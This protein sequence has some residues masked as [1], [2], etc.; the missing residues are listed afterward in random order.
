[1]SSIHYQLAYPDLRKN[2]HESSGGYVEIHD[3]HYN[4]EASKN[5]ETAIFLAQRGFKVRLLPVD[6]TPGIKNPDAYLID[7]KLIIEF[8]HNQTPTASAIEN[9]LRDAKKQADN[10]L[11]HV[12]GELTKGALIRG[13]QNRLHRDKT[14]EELWLIFSQ[15]LYRFTP[16]EVLNGSIAHK[17]Q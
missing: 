4:H 1:M 3:M 7:E 17:I 10:I 5:L 14:V 13:L 2:E 11:I 9:E 16:V 8:K 12:Q 6:N 15:E